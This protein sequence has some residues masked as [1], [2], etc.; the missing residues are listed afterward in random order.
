MNQATFVHEHENSFSEEKKEAFT[1]IRGE[2]HGSRCFAAIV[3]EVTRVHDHLT[4]FLMITISINSRY[5]R[6]FS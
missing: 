5:C 4:R 6:D 1:A 2:P 3:H